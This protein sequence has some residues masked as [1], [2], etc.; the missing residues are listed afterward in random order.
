MQGHDAGY[1][2]RQG[3]KIR[4]TANDIKRNDEAL[5]EELGEEL[6]TIHA[7]FA[8]TASP[9]VVDRV[10][11]KMVETYPL[12]RLDLDVRRDD[13]DEGVVLQSP[14]RAH[15]SSRIFSRANRLGQPAPYYQ[16]RDAAMST[17]GPY[18]P[19]WIKELLTVKIG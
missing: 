10:I 16:Y 12:S 13:T 9:S 19:D 8:G 4:S 18:R 6:S 5:A 1:W 15:A 3:S 2:M 11:N 17:L 14:E 7:T